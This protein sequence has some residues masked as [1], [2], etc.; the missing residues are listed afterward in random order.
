[1]ANDERD[2]PE[3]SGHPFWPVHVIDQGIQFYIWVGLILTLA[4][5]IP[6]K[7][8][9]QADPLVTPPGI[10]PEW[11]FLFMFQTLKYIP[12]KVL[13]IDGEILG[14]LL[15]GF[16]GLLWTL[17]PFWDRK[18]SRGERN[19]FVTYLGLFAVIYIM[20]FTIVGWVA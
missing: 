12:G 20:I 8:H 16:A 13:F 2:E 18:S 3:E 4:I 15:F 9:A 14:V 19:R 10:K 11:Y 7:L 6:M 17:V 5:M 1:M